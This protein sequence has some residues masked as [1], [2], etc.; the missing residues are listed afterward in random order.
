MATQ[1]ANVFSQEIINEILQ[2]PE[3]LQAK[4]KIDQQT[5]GSVYFTIEVTDSIQTL[6][7]NSF[8]IDL[9]SVEK[10]P[11]RWIKGDTK[12]HI[13]IATKSFEKTHLVYL[14]DSSGELVV[15]GTT[16]PITQGTGYTFSEQSSHETIGTGLEPRLLFGPMSETGFSVGGATTIYADGQTEIIYFSYISGSGLFYKINDGSLTGLSLPIT[17]VNTNTSY[18]LKVLFE[19]S[20]TIEN[21]IAYFVC[22]SENIQFGS[23]SLDA[24]GNRT[25][26]TIDVNNYPG[27]IRNGDSTSSGFNNIYVYNLVVNG[28]GYQTSYAGGWIGQEYFGRGANNNYITNCLSDGTIDDLGGGIVGQT[29]GSFGGVLTLQGCSSSGSIGSYGGGIAGHYA[30]YLNG[31]VRCEQCWSTG[32][33]GLEGGGIFGDYGGTGGSASATKCYSEGLIGQG[34]GGIFGANAAESSGSATAEKCYSKGNIQ[35][36]GGGIYGK[37]AGFNSGTTFAINCYSSG[38]VTTSGTGIYGSSKA[39]GTA[40]NCYIANGSWSTASANSSLQGVPSGSSVGTTWVAATANQPYELNAFGFSPYTQNVII[41]SS[42]DLVQNYSQT[43][44]QGQSSDSA[45]TADASGNA[46]V[47]LEKSGGD[48]SSYSTITISLQTGSISTTSATLPGTYIITVY[49]TGSYNITTFTLTINLA[50]TITD[51][52][53]SKSLD[54][55]YIDYRTR[56]EIL[57][58]NMIISNISSRRTAISYSDLIKMKMAYAAKIQI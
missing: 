34:S 18:R 38:S 17:I 4:S 8:G 47:I 9:S 42:S 31:S 49:S 6:V 28:T 3:V 10:I 22:G 46:F 39:N 36:D 14:T 54:L 43:I 33:I 23:E 40:T 44:Q 27:L 41:A 48:S 57:A 50:V 35:T 55:Q 29:A 5:S 7:Y 45:L 21:T 11:M 12:P 13:D 52:C 15:D 20:I 1:I 37:L 16:Y 56:N 53:C 32:S 24:S 25:F 19:T 58:G 51:D 30:G 2:F 26:I